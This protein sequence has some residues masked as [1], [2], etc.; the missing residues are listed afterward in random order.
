[1]PCKVRGD[2]KDFLSQ[3]ALTVH[4]DY[5]K[6]LGLE[7]SEGRFFDAQKDV[8]RGNKIVINEA[9]KKFWKIEDIQKCRILNKYWEDST[10]YEIIGVVKDFNYQ[11]LSVKP[12]PLF[13]L[14][15]A[16]ADNYFLIKFKDGFV[17]SDLQSVSRL[18]KEVNPGEDFTFSFLS[19]EIADLYQKEKK[20]SQI[21][22]VFTI[23]AL[24][25][26]AIGIFVI[27]IYDA[28][29]RTKEIG[30]RKVNGAQIGEI[31]LMLNKD[32]VKL[33]LL[34]FIIACPIV[35]YAMHK[36]LENF[37]YKIDI[38]WWIFILA[39]LLAIGIAVLTVSWQ[40]W[41]VAGRNPVES[42][43]YE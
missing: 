37:A 7:I 10:G 21:Y 17:Q 24:F 39:G 27:A 32:F 19:D 41:R 12:Q 35:W 5:L 4:P 1:M 9:A 33:V 11:H 16:D 25:I 20:L 28:Q 29:R 34:A 23:I 22:L 43:K 42:L 30:I 14:Y 2:E 13:M 36:W 40:S 38:S 31:M 3:N 6:L 26:T 8:S 18:Y 15:F